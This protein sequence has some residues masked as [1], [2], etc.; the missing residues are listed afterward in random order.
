MARV[1]YSQNAAQ[2]QQVFTSLPRAYQ[3]NKPGSDVAVEI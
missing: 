2:V 1:L 3:R